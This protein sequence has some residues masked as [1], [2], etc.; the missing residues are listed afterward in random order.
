MDKSMAPMDDGEHMMNR[1]YEK[2]L[3][4]M[5]TDG[6]QDDNNNNTVQQ[7]PRK[8]SYAHTVHI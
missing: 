3:Y 2:A 7:F 8:K 6:R 5:H 1:K 4:V